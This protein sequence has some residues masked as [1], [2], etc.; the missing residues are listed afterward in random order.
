MLCYA[1][2]CYA[3]LCRAALRCA[4]V[5]LPT[6]QLTHHPTDRLSEERQ[7]RR[8]AHTALAA[9]SQI[10]SV[11]TYYITPR[12]WPGLAWPPRAAPAAPRGERGRYGTN[13]IQSAACTHSTVLYHPP[14]HPITVLCVCMYRTTQ[15][16]LWVV[17]LAPF[18]C[19]DRYIQYREYSA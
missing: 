10:N 2:L 19:R 11:H 7:V 17:H 4:A 6:T 13:A 15:Q 14:S 8:A 16:P 3:M 5:V 12:P 1:M 9:C 18:A